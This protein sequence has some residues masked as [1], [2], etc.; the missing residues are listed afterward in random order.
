MSE[1]KRNPVLTEQRIG[2]N[3]YLRQDFVVTAE[4]GTT[5]DDVLQPGYWAHVAGRFQKFDRI[6]VRQETGEWTMDLI[7]NDAGRN[8]A[9]V[10]VMH[11]YDL[12]PASAEPPVALEHKVEWK[13]PH[14]KFCVIR[15]SDGS[16]LQEGFPDRSAAEAWLKNHEA[17]VTA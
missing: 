7:V 9:K 10:H 12:A 3:D 4:E 17:V 13:G 8:W 2:G 14:L 11:V 5:K 16:K 6:E 1:T 15:V